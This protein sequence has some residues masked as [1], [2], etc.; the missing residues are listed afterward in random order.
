MFYNFGFE[1]TYYDGSIGGSVY[2]PID[3][4]IRI[5][6]GEKFIITDEMTLGNYPL[7]VRAG[8]ILQVPQS[9]YDLIGE[10]FGNWQSRLEVR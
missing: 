4:P 6:V 2:E 1:K 10:K 8:I 9:T 3:E 7:A 5:D